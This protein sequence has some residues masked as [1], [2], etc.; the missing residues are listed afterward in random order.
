[1]PGYFAILEKRATAFITA[2]LQEQ[3][4]NLQ[5]YTVLAQ[6]VEYPLQEEDA[7]YC[8]VWP[9]L[10]RKIDPSE[11]MIKAL[12]I[13][14]FPWVK[15]VQ[16]GDNFDFKQ[17]RSAIDNI[18]M[19]L[20]KPK[21]N[22]SFQHPPPSNIYPT[23]I[24]PRFF[25]PPRLPVPNLP[26]MIELPRPS[27]PGF[28]SKVAGKKRELF[29]KS[30]NINNNN[31]VDLPLPKRTAKK[32]AART[33]I[34]R[35]ISSPTVL[36]TTNSSSTTVAA[37]LSNV[38]DAPSTTADSLSTAADAL[39]TVADVSSTATDAPSIVAAPSTVVDVLSIVADEPFTVAAAPSTV[40][41]EPSIIADV[42]PVADKP[43]DAPTQLADA[44]STVTDAP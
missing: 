3:E 37:A 17:M 42:P 41:Y 2:V 13:P 8:L 40:A 28:I 43:V 34:Q 36:S 10:A 33:S 44:S 18:P 31:I 39:S 26:Q 7:R 4:E 5:D 1:M 23:P 19:R 30:S 29:T 24:T 6:L 21:H 20:E 32:V 35:V 14:R 27:F 38:T 9:V 22:Y 11:V 15:R 25:S 16:T 12:V